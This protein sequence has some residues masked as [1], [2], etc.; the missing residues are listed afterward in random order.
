M[1]ELF[2]QRTCFLLHFNEV[3]P[4]DNVIS[5]DV[6]PCKREAQKHC[7]KI[8][9]GTKLTVSAHIAVVVWTITPERIRTTIAVSKTALETDLPV[10]KKLPL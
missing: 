7:L 5:T 1:L 4:V 10:V 9:R 2:G 6:Q 8:A 3:V